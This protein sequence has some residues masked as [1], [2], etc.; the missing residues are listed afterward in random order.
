MLGS[1]YHGSPE[2]NGDSGF[3]QGEDSGDHQHSESGRPNSHPETGEGFNGGDV[4]DGRG[5]GESVSGRPD[6]HHHDQS[7]SG[8]H[9]GD[10]Q[11]S[12]GRW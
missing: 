10:S 2:S 8:F 9:D 3:H 7:G 4:P 11:G 1:G 6:A 12:G 5:E